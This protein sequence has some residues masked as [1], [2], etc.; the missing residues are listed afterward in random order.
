MNIDLILTE[1][2]FRLPKGYPTSAKDYEVL[3]DVLIETAKITPDEARQIVERAKGNVKDYITESLKLD[4]IQNQFLTK[5]IQEVNK[6]DDLTKFLSLLP[7]EAEMPTLKFLNNLSYEQ[8]QNFANILYSEN[9]V[10]EQILN[11][12][13][14]KS[15]I[16]RDLFQLHKAGL[17][18]GEI[19]L[20]ALIRDSFIQGG[21]VSY[22]L[23]VIITI[24]TKTLDVTTTPPI[25]P[26]ENILLIEYG[27]STTKVN[28]TQQ[29]FNN[30]TVNN[31]IVIPNTDTSRIAYFGIDPAPNDV[32]KVFIT[33]N[34]TQKIYDDNFII[35]IDGA[36]YVATTSTSTPPSPSVIPTPVIP[37]SIMP[38][39]N[40]LSISYGIYNSKKD[41]TSICFNKINSNKIVI[42]SADA[43]RRA[44]FGIDPAYGKVKQVFITKNG[45]TLPY[46]GDYVVIINAN[47]YDV[48][49]TPSSPNI[50]QYPNIPPVSSIRISYGIYN[51]KKD[52]T[53][54]CFNQIDIN[55]NI[56]IPSADPDR[57]AYF[58]IDPAYGKVKQVFITKNGVT[59]PY[60]GDYVVTINANTYDVTTTPSSP[61]IPQ[62]PNIPP[63]SS[64]SISYGI[65]NNK[66][67]V[68][69]SCFNQIDINNNIVIPSDDNVRLSYFGV[70][71]P[72]PGVL[73]AVFITT[74]GT[75]AVEYPATY[76]IT[77]NATTYNVTTVPPMP[78]PVNPIPI[79]PM[80]LNQVFDTSIPDYNQIVSN[81]TNIEKRLT[82]FNNS[83]VN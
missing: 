74:K 19:L 66:V 5:A 2:C 3:Y 47:T 6:I 51:S 50:P 65:S 70:I 53:S 79:K 26:S 18:K 25:A 16:Y 80:P 31:K 23:N 24:D 68:T 48:T 40:I 45:V 69:S 76:T 41:V 58:G 13:N 56:V 43:D 8:A 33:T 60:S 1:W 42:P 20:A 52:V 71:D 28:V 78:I 29:S 83:L 73:K 34:G 7:V 37:T 81:N 49:T 32:K 46:S 36:T 55:N 54:I 11:S 64:I 61:N 15:G 59:L 75:P 17:G 27:T 77:I 14:F 22:D 12:F 62:Y 82:S 67:V 44:Y 63:L 39:P 9:S 30:Y 38:A 72:A 21:N 4:S 57:R 10:T 35:T